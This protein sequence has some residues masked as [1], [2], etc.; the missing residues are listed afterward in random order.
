MKW[1]MIIVL[2]GYIYI[3]VQPAMSIGNDEGQSPRVEHSFLLRVRY[4]DIIMKL[5]VWLFYPTCLCNDTM[6]LMIS[7]MLLSSENEDARC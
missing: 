1:S 6:S 4:R 3:Y 2:R 5:W 7:L